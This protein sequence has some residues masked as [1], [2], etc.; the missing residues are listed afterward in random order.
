MILIFDNDKNSKKIFRNT[1][2]SYGLSVT[3]KWIKI[4]ELKNESNSDPFL[5]LIT[6]AKVND[7]I[8]KFAANK[9]QVYNLVDNRY[10]ITVDVKKM[11]LLGKN[12]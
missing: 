6:I 12:K 5:G 8:N 11:E 10:N 1:N 4:V 3:M 7:Y 2:D 9:S